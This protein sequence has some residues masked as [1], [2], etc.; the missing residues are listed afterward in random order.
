MD[1]IAAENISFSYDGDES[2]LVLDD[3]SLSV[4][5]GSFLAVIGTNGS[6][7]S[8]LARHFNALLPINSGSLR[9][10]GIDATNPTQV[11][12]VRKTCGMIF[13]NPNN[14]FV[15]SLVREEVAFGLQNFDFPDNEIPVRVHKALETV[16][17]ENYEDRDPHSLSGGQ[18]QR[19]A[20]A[21]VYAV[22]PDILIFDEATSMLD[23]EGRQEVLSLIH[24]L[25]QQGCTIIM[26]T[27][28]IEEAVNADQVIVMS[29]GKVLAEGSPEAI[30]TDRTLL[31]QAHLVPPLA[32]RLYWYL[33][34]QFPGRFPE[35]SAPLTNEG[36]AQLLCR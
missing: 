15:S 14:Q 18:K 4:Q 2:N 28:Y 32:T 27:H 33:V 30:L 17:L 26:I 16:H 22:K 13:Q 34:E 10:A 3:V 12:N 6:G 20:I 23:P 19:L 8:T 36:L 29:A 21:S 7:K 9:I 11:W 31:S 1:I 35:Y 25:H 24:E 5:R